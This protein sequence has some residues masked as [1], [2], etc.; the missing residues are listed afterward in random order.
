[1]IS[2]LPGLRIIVSPMCTLGLV[3]PSLPYPL[4][5]YPGF[6]FPWTL[7]YEGFFKPFGCDTVSVCGLDGR[8]ILYTCD[9]EFLTRFAS[10]AGAALFSK[11]IQD[12][13]ILNYF[14]S[15][16]VTVEG[17]DWVRHRKITAP[18]FSKK[19][20]TRLWGDMRS[21][22][23]DMVA[24]EGWENRTEGFDPSN[25]GHFDSMGEYVPAKG[26]IYFPH[27]VDMT[28][29]MTLAAIA[30]TGFGIT[31]EWRTKSSFTRTCI[32][33]GESFP[34]FL[35]RVIL[36][37]IYTLFA[38]ILCQLFPLPLQAHRD[39][40]FP[41][42]STGYSKLYGWISRG[43]SVPPPPA[44][45]MRLQEALHIVA[46]ESTLKLALLSLPSWISKLPFRRLNR[47]NMALDCLRRELRRTIDLRR[48]QI[49]MEP[50]NMKSSA[51]PQT[52]TSG[53]SI[54]YYHSDDMNDLLSNL[55]RSAL[56][57]QANGGPVLS[58]DEIIG[59]AYIYLLAGHETTAHSLAWMLALLA[60]YPDK[61]EKLYEEIIEQDHSNDTV[62]EDYPKFRYAL[63]TYYETLRLFPPVQQ[64]P[65]RVEHDTIIT[66][67]RSNEKTGTSEE[68][69]PLTPDYGSASTSV[70]SFQLLP[71][72]GS[73]AQ[74][75]GYFPRLNV[76]VS[77]N[78]FDQALYGIPSLPS[79]P[80]RHDV[81]Q[82]ISS[83]SSFS[84]TLSLSTRS[85][86][87]TTQ[88]LDKAAPSDDLVAGHYHQIVVKKGTVI[89]ITPPGV[90]YNP[91]YWP[92]PN[93]FHPERFLRAYNKDAFIPFGVGSRACLG[94]K[95]SEVES[96][97][98]IIHLLRSYSVHLPLKHGE[99]IE[100]ARQAFSKASV[101]ITLTP[102]KVPIIFRKRTSY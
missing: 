2:G 39:E 76:Q 83:N 17:K 24:T 19:M 3:L 41:T 54:H 78:E 10:R 48:Y 23:Q 80:S 72:I 45:D 47:M 94:R 68:Q 95:F 31:F 58:E 61:Q 4:M 26:E 84:T 57:S 44:Q 51:F 88:E 20:F 92:N 18:A 33:F 74:R 15:N 79:T 66:F 32:D 38:L 90:H 52:D 35:H 81:F 56:A 69:V 11:P 28:L 9:V 53:T 100:Q 93:E 91:K 36:I 99:T 22:V 97:C 67:E 60:A 30:R 85:S 50:T 16:L 101:R 12:Y 21:I 89:F 65:K 63:A 13:A 34:T 14:G 73:H 70:D 75:H 6:A 5:T 98:M 62:L 59:N 25:P 49:A 29:H 37:P 77:Y 96:V 87:S 46:R 82:Y 43:L 1:M 102:E 8:A 64:I 55:V 86:F 7:K 40:C 42:S 71:T 27:V